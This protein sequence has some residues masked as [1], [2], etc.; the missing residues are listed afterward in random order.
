MY[1][2][3]QKPINQSI[4]NTR[5]RNLHLP[6]LPNSNNLKYNKIN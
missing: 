6:N 1:S 5:L 4:I 2:A 3:Y